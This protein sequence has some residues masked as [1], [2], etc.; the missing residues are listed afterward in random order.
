M[1]RVTLVS[2]FALIAIA[3]FFSACQ[4]DSLSGAVDELSV[5]TALDHT[6]IDQGWGTDLSQTVKGM[7][8]IPFKAKFSTFRQEDKES[9]VSC[10]PNSVLPGPNYQEGG[11]NATHLGKFKTVIT[12]CAGANGI[13][14]N[15][16]GYLEAANGDRLFIEIESGQV[17]VQ[18]PPVDPF[19][20]AY[21]KD[22]FQFVG[23]TGRFEGATGGGMTNSLVDLWNDE[24]PFPG[25]IIEGHRT[26]HEFTGTL[27]LPNGK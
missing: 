6:A 12:F 10:D 5:Q 26:D 17:I 27:I 4:K 19:Y 20:D 11:G 13:Y 23:G 8:E 3:L 2:A 21:F 16:S 24:F 15:G 22:P 1:K 14:G 7:R 18:I 25:P 9:M